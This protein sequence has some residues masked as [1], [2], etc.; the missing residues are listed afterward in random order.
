MFAPDFVTELSKRVGTLVVEVQTDGGEFSGTL[1]RVSA[2]VIV[3]VP[4]GVYPTNNSPQ[5]ISVSSIN[6]VRFLPF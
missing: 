2:E 4:F 3:V 1:A 5:Y 6:F